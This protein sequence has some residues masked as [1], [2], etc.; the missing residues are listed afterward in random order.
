MG[1]S[2]LS[3]LPLLFE[4]SLRAVGM[5]LVY[6]VERN[7][8]TR[9]RLTLP[10]LMGRIFVTCVTGRVFGLRFEPRTMGSEGGGKGGDHRYR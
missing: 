7:A 10:M 4:R 8:G 2:S 9:V 3:G 5:R 6:A 1:G